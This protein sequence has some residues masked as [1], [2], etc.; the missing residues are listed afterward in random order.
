MW[1]YYKKW[2]NATCEIVKCNVNENV[3][4]SNSQLNIFKSAI[5]NATELTLKLS[6]YIF[7]YSDDET[8]FWHKLLLTGRQVSKLDQA[9]ENNSSV[10]I[11]LIKINY[12]K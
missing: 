5:K 9:F 12:L 10:N 2:L 8:N 7:G 11:K 1:Y 6:S 3:K 4:V